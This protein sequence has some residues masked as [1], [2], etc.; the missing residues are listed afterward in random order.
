M[1]NRLL[2]LAWP[3]PLPSG[4]KLLL[5]ALADRADDTGKSWPSRAMLV[6]QTGLSEVTLWRHLRDLVNAGLVTQQRR[7]QSSTVYTVHE[8]VLIVA[9]KRPEE[10][11]SL[12]PETV[13]NETL[14]NETVHSDDQ[15]RSKLKVSKENP[16]EPPTSL[17]DTPTRTLPD[18]F[19]EFWSAYP[20][21]GGRSMNKDDARKAWTAAVKAIRKPDD[22][23]ISWTVD[24][25]IDGTRR[26]AREC[27]SYDDPG[28]VKMP[29]GWLRAGGWKYDDL[30]STPRDHAEWIKGEWRAGRVI[31]IRKYFPGDYSD[32]PPGDGDYL[33]DVLKP[34]NRAWIERHHAAILAR[35][36]SEAS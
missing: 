34:H 20:K 21:R 10:C 27:Q 26:F 31:E 18:R 23:G 2:N 11:K 13:Q 4:A 32:P 24:Q 36:T 30:T 9:A 29:A 8:A 28:R 25:I 22:D 35:L 15:N 1:S 33:E 14:Q 17:S 19:A 16:H 5:V 12:H 7:R 3:V 6:E